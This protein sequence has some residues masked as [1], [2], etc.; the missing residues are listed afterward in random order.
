MNNERSGESHGQTDISLACCF[1]NRIDQAI[2]L[3][4]RYIPEDENIRRVNFFAVVG[5]IQSVPDLHDCSVQ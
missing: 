2:G 4:V 5:L 3:G 1:R